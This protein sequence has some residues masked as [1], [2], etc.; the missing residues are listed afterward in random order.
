VKR[1]LFHDQH[2]YER[3]HECY[4]EYEY[5]HESGH[6]HEH[7]YESMAT[8]VKKS[9]KLNAKNTTNKNLNGTVSLD[10]ILQ[11]TAILQAYTILRYCRAYIR[12]RDVL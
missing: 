2:E 11:Q 1:V 5:K 4:H 10:P 8:R 9:V 3:E 6:E 7:G 12:S